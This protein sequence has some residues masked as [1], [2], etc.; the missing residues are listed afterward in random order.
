MGTAQQAGRLEGSSQALITSLRV[1]PDVS[2]I[3]KTFDYAVPDTMALPPVGSIVRIELHG[4]RVDAWVL[5]HVDASGANYDLKPVISVLSVGPPTEVVDLARWAAR[6]CAG[7]LRAVLASASPDKRI[8]HVRSSS[9]SKTGAVSSQRSVSPQAEQLLERG[10]GV[11]VLPPMRPVR[12]VLE[13]VL[14]RGRVLVVCPAVGFARIVAGALRR[15]GLSVALMPDDWQRAAEGVDVVVG[16]RSA[17]WAPCPDMAGI[18]VFDEHDE[19][20]QDERSP[21]WHARDIAIERAARLGVPCLLV[22]PLPTVAAVRWAGPERVV[23]PE[24]QDGDWP[25]IEIVDPFTELGDEEA[26]KAGLLS[27]ALIAEL[28]DPTRTVACVLN[29]KGRARLLTCKGCHAVARCEKCDA[30]MRDMG[31]GRLECPACA[32]HR[33]HV[34]QK[35]GGA[36]LVLARKGVQ[37][38]ME[39]IQAAANRPVRDVT[40]ATDTAANTSAN[41]YVGTEALLHRVASADVVA[42]LDFDNEVFAPTYRAAEHAWSLVILAARVLRGATN[43]RI[44]LQSNDATNS[45]VAEFAH[46]EPMRI[47]EVEA[48]KRRQLSLPPFSHMARVVVG[49]GQPNELSHPPLGVAVAQVNDREFLVR[50]D[51]ADSFVEFTNVL[52]SAHARVYTDPSRY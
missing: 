46:P 33:P 7:P 51:E 12:P 48:E 32:N 22:S 13:A 26:P 37:R 43:G 44:I 47:L 40:G 19:R 5:E 23:W 1:V 45:L 8:K 20:L 50:G 16:A 38:A 4:R 30:A 2:G 3:D 39:E 27:S 49:D 21:T 34:C 9:P 17:V 10:G 52:R 35:C 24:P 36:A 25:R 6:R 42:F 31:D 41:V 28:R 14:R 18:V 15:E 29:V 11:V